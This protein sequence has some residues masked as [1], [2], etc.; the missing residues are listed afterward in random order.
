MVDSKSQVAADNA[1]EKEAHLSAFGI[2]KK[3]RVNAVSCIRGKSSASHSK[4]IG[5]AVSWTSLQAKSVVTRI[6]EK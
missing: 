6:L 1:Q 5:T 4:V 3:L 2:L